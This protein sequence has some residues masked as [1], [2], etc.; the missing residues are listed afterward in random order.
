MNTCPLQNACVPLLTDPPSAYAALAWQDEDGTVITEDDDEI[1]FID[2]ALAPGV[3]I[4][5]DADGPRLF[6]AA[7]KR[8]PGGTK[9]I[10]SPRYFLKVTN[11]DEN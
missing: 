3:T 9:T 2:D 6:A 8:I 10:Q 5:F 1:I 7:C 4:I 11:P